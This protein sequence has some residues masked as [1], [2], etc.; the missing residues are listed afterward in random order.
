MF[1]FSA[2]PDFKADEIAASAMELLRDKETV[3]G[4]RVTALQVATILK[5]PEAVNEARKLLAAADTGV[6]LKMSAFSTI[7]QLGSAAQDAGKTLQRYTKGGCDVR[8]AVAAR[9]ALARLHQPAT[10]TKPPPPLQPTGASPTGNYSTHEMSTTDGS[11]A[12]CGFY[13]VFH[14]EKHGKQQHS[15]EA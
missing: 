11:V 8:L 2:L 13:C 1:R 4:S 15:S 10:P 12:D 14:S 7:G 9:A 5:H 6:S 3:I